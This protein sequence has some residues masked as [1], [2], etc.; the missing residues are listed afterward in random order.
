[1]K[2]TYAAC[3]LVLLLFLLWLSCDRDY[4]FLVPVRFPGQTQAWYDVFSEERAY[5]RHL[6]P[7]GAHFS[8]D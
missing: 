3:G 7:E 2:P 8:D 4:V 6:A 1:M 5:L